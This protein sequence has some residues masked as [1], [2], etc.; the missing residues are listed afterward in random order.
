M[1]RSKKVVISHSQRKLLTATL[2]RYDALWS[3]ARGLTRDEALS[4]YKARQA[5]YG[6]HYDGMALTA[7][8]LVA[9]GFVRRHNYPRT[10]AITDA[11]DQLARSWVG[12]PSLRD[13]WIWLS[14]IGTEAIAEEELICSRT[15]EARLRLERELRPLLIRGF[16]HSQSERWQV[17]Y[18]RIPANS[19]GQA[20][21]EQVPPAIDKG[22]AELYYQVFNAARRD[23]QVFNAARRVGD[24]STEAA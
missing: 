10:I 12:L 2:A 19:A 6:L 21:P 9:A 22:L 4:V 7:M 3:P 18:Y 5:T 15:R 24:V 13:S 20:T 11:G 1:E 14:Q 8:P 23:Y 17:W 16:V